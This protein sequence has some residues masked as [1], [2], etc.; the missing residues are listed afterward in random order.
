MTTA[1]PCEHCRSWPSPDFSIFY[2]SRINLAGFPAE[3][4]LAGTSF[5][6]TL[7]AATTAPATIVTPFSTDTPNPSQAPSPIETA[8]RGTLDQSIRPRYHPRSAIDVAYQ[9]VG[10][11]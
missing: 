9:K 3:R 4:V 5:V 6:T 11:V 10:T 1:K 2:R 8:A 7:P